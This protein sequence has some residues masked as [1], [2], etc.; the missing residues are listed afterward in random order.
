MDPLQFLRLK[1]WRHPSF[2]NDF[3]GQRLETRASQRCR[4]NYF[5]TLEMEIVAPANFL[6]SRAPPPCCVRGGSG[7]QAISRP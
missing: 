5:L 1:G 3:N 7:W 4:N 6:V 2:R